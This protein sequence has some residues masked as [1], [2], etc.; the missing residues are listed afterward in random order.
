MYGQSKNEINIVHETC[1]RILR[2]TIK[3]KM[4]Y[5]FSRP[6][7]LHNSPYYR[8]VMLWNKMPAN[9][10]TCKVKLEFKKLVHTWTK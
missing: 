10:Q 9:I 3:V 5:K 4:K 2:S 1:D 6:T 8:G 7:K